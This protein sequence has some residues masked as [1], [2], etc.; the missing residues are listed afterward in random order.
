[1]ETSKIDR[2]H[3]LSG[4]WVIALLTAC[5]FAACSGKTEPPKAGVASSD[6]ESQKI[7]VS[8]APVVERATNR[9]LEVVGSLE[10]QDEVTVSTQSSG[11]LQEILVDVGTPVRRGQ[12]ISRI[13]DREL[14]LKVEQADATLRQAEARLG[15]KRGERI[16]PQKQPDVRQARAGLERARYDFKAA[17]NLVEQG[18]ISRQQ[19]DVAQKMLEQADARYQAS[20]ENVRNLEAALEEKRAALALSRKQLADTDIISPTSGIVKQK[21]ASRGEYLQTGTPVA[22]IVQVNPL[23]LKLEVPEAFAAQIARGQSVS[24]RVDTFPDREFNGAIARINPSLDDKN[25]SLVA[26]AEVPTPAGLLK[27]GMFARVQVAPTTS[28]AALMVPEKAVVSV[29]GVNKLFV[30]EGDRAMERQIKLGNRDGSLVEVL[31]GVRVGDRVITSN[32]EK[33]HDGITVAAS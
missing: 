2:Y 28:V 16:D 33:L 26:E 21:L 25:R 32:T 5:L 15:V 9:N 29:A 17:E 20:L 12:V 14:K 24:L 1:M 11:N 13:D 4:L 7:S 10:A 19:F 3:K 27:P 31:E 8:T 6:A 22:I 18:D 23:R 30:L